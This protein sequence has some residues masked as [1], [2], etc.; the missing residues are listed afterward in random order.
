MLHPSRSPAHL[1][2]SRRGR[3]G[4]GVDAR[5]LTSRPRARALYRPQPVRA[6]WS[7]RRSITDGAITARR[8]VS[9][10]PRDGS[11]CC[12]PSRASAAPRWHNRD[13]R[14]AT[15]ST[16]PT[17]PAIALGSRSLARSTS[18]TRRFARRCR[19]ACASGQRA[20]ITRCRKREVALHPAAI[21]AAVCRH[22]ECSDDARRS[23]RT[24]DAR[25]AFAAICVELCGSERSGSHLKIQLRPLP[26]ALVLR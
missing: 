1:Q 22:F 23:R 21:A 14:T 17:R 26:T 7:R 18:A 15:T 16:P 4:S 10:R 25:A 19:T 2:D 24:R 13:R 5:R 3:A 11:M 8:L 9:N 20:A 6:G 12:G